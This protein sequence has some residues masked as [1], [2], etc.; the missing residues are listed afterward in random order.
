MERAVLL[1]SKENKLQTAIGNF[2]DA[3]RP[4]IEAALIGNKPISALHLREL[5]PA[6]VASRH[7][8]ELSV[9]TSISPLL[10]WLPEKVN[11]GLVQEIDAMLKGKMIKPA[12]SP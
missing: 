10:H 6:E 11:M 9:C 1:V 4:S 3:E 8:F 2:T 7:A 5:H 12:N